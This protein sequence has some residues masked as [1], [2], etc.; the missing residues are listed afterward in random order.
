MQKLTEAIKHI[1]IINVI[2]FLVPQLL[3]LDFTNILALHFPENEHFGFWQYITNTFM[4]FD[5]PHIAFNMLFIWMFGSI[6]EQTWGRNKF[7][8]FYFSAGIGASIIY[9]LVNYFQFNSIYEIFI[10]AGLNDSEIISILK[11]GSTND[12]RIVNIIT[13]E[14]FNRI[15]S[16]YNGV[17]IG[18][19]GALYGIFAASAVMYPNM[20]IR[21]LFLPIPLV[22]KYYMLI[23]ILSD[24]FLGII[25]R[26][27]DN[28]A[29]F[30]H[31]GGAIV[32]GLIAY[33]WKKNHFKSI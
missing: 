26:E 9:T 30:A 8:F 23:L 19:S 1:I 20:E 27:N 14:Q 32:G 29:R 3:Q 22:N 16:L 33:Y 15:T 21:L 31:V 6:L 5:I 4:H 24:L 7:L 28:I 17:A 18:A 12:L 10:N 11:K 2:V 25:S 13:Q